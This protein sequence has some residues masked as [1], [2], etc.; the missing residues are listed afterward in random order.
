M[1]VVAEILI[2]R[3]TISVRLLLIKRLIKRLINNNAIVIL[4]IQTSKISK[5]R[6]VD[7]L[8]ERDHENSESSGLIH[9][10]LNLLNNACID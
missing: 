8:L 10:M 7:E 3:Y 9:K 2:K 6:F 5:V 4:G 1:E